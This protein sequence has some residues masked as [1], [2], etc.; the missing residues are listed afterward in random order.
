[1]TESSD[2]AGM[3]AGG[4]RADRGSERARDIRFRV[5]REIHTARRAAGLSLRAA[6]AAVGV[7]A[8]AFSRIERGLGAGL[9]LERLCLACAAVGLEFGGRAFL[10]GDPVRDAG[11]LR[12]L[13][14]IRERLPP[15]SPWSLEVPLPGP[16]DQRAIDAETLLCGRRVGF[17][18]EL[19]L[20]DIQALERRLALKKRDAGLGL[21]VLVVAETRHN[22]EVLAVHRDA[23]RRSFPLDSRQVLGALHRGEPPVRDGLVVI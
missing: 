8:S 19:Q 9:S 22:R 13:G 2:P 23:L 5:G 7:S 20:E 6:G 10:D 11:H 12:L 1:M 18:A 14:R 4:R 15:G 16:G 21:L 3:A 17:E